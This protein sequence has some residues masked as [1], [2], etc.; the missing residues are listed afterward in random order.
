[1]LHELLLA[2]LG[3][4]GQVIIIKS[5]RAGFAV[6]PECDFI[7]SSETDL[8]GRLCAVATRA[9][10]VQQRHAMLLRT[11]SASDVPVE[12]LLDDEDEEDVDFGEGP[13]TLHDTGVR[14]LR[15]S[16]F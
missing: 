10:L 12:A 13:A 15:N 16:V 5:D 14:P 4:P 3:M 11:C 7:S 6:A 9:K 1:M 8:L 2:L